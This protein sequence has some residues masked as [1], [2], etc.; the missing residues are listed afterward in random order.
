MVLESLR[1]WPTSPLI[2]RE[3]TSPTEWSAGEIQARTGIVI[4]A[5][6]FHR[7]DERLPF[8]DRFLPEL[9][10]DETPAE[11]WP[12]IPFSEGPAACPG[13]NLVLLLCS[14]MLAAILDNARVRLVNAT[15]LRGSE[16][17]PATLNHF[18][19]RFEL[20]G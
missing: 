16:K 9:W 5:P 20:E 10:L 18:G 7:D 14:G 11:G 4:F 15:R 19:L 12:L 3:T 8:A 1:L 2:L 13:R 17:P 6:F